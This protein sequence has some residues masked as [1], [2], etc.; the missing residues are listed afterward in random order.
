MPQTIVIAGSG[1]AGLWAAISAA[2]AVSLAGKESEVEITVVSPAPNL[3]IRPRLY[4][5]AL[6]EMNPDL[7]ALFGELGVRHLAGYVDAIDPEEKLVRVTP[8][9]GA[10]TAL[11]YDRFILATGS[12]LFRPDVPGLSEYAFDVD[13]LPS[14]RRLAA[15]LAGLAGRPQT[16][17]RNTVVVIGGGLTG[18]ET[19][20]E[21][22]SR[23]RDALGGDAD[24]R[25][26]IVDSAEEIGAG[27]G[28]APLPF[29]REA[30]AEAGVEPRVRCRAAAIDEA[31]VTLS[32]GSR[33]DAATVIWT[34]GMRAHPLAAAI[35]G[36]HD[37]LGRVIGDDYLHAPAAPGVFVAGDA[38]RAAAD[39]VGHASVMSCQF[40][41][42]LGR[43]AGHNAA[44][45]LVGL[46]LHRYAQ[47]NYVTCLDL[48]P[49]G[50]LYTEGWE[51]QVRFR[52]EEGKAI[53]Q[54]INRVWIYPPAANREAAFATANPD[55]VIVA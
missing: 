18:L 11:P 26:V 14:A 19:A 31:G 50:A 5:A 27:M 45:E 43:V 30:L 35:P 15:H 23:L 10:R 8:V 39:D 6:E 13:T 42:S 28:A 52:R 36:A 40:G 9:K 17:A 44:A 49:W 46:P 55:H 2:R 33:I 34:A 7:S 37:E 16:D 47:P 4:E 12:T 25:V 54:E 1:F 29:I 48:G 41:L 21:M 32:D 20:T 22:P 51:R 24:I 3:A 38:V 53:K